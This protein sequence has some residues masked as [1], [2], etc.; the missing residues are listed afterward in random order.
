M[1]TFIGLTTGVISNVIERNYND[2][3]AEKHF[4]HVCYLPGLLTTL[5]SMFFVLFASNEIGQLFDDSLFTYFSDIWNWI[6]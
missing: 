5:S 4:H 6:D 2:H 3:A 1:I